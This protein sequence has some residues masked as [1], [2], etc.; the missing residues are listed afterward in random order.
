VLRVYTLGLDN[1]RASLTMIMMRVKALTVLV[2]CILATAVASAQ[3]EH[4]GV[5]LHNRSSNNSNENNADAITFEDA[6][7]FEFSAREETLEWPWSSKSGNKTQQDNSCSNHSSCSSCAQ[8][9][10]CHWCGHDETCHVVGSMYGCV[11]GTSCEK[12]PPKNETD[13]SGCTAHDT[14]S[15]CALASHL[16]H[17]CA[18]DNACHSVGSVYG[19]VTGV[20]C[21]SNDRCKRTEPELIEN[22]AFTEIGPIPLF[23]LVLLGSLLCCCASTCMCVAGGVKGAYDD[24]AGF[25]GGAESEPL[26]VQQGARS[27]TSWDTEV[28]RAAPTVTVSET[29][30][31]ETSDDVVT[32]PDADDAA[33]DSVHL[34]RTEEGTNTMTTGG[35]VRLV[36]LANEGGQGALVAEEDAPLIAPQP[37]PRRRTGH[38]QRMY[39]VC[40]ASYILTMAV[41][42]A[43]FV[44]GVHYFP[45]KPVYNICNDNLAWK[46]L[47]D[48]MASMKLSADFE[49]LASVNN[50]NHFDVALDMGTGSF[51]HDGAFVGTFDIPPVTVQAMAITDMMISKLTLIDY[52]AVYGNSL[53]P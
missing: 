26:L 37:R 33:T 3:G 17:W 24:L 21:Y 15:D 2:V 42:I 4:N 53:S 12:P 48:N 5:D 22:T 27:P 46:E 19:C 32:E 41:I 44:A 38:M 7:A 40:V 28:P 36:D 23:V 25:S 50:P 11:S 30:E 35:Y 1:D 52:N 45:S 49:L 39:N 6:P 18:H 34:A 51:Y 29:T 16:C 9:S 8:S 13:P 43:G 31:E 20:D 47:I 10:W 14:C